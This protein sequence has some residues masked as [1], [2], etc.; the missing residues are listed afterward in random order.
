MKKYFTHKSALVETEKIGTKTRIWA[1]VHILPGATIGKNV[2]ICDNVFIENDVLIGN[3]VTIKNGAI[4]FDGVTLEDSV[5]IGPGVVFTNDRYPRSKRKDYKL[6][7]VII[8]KGATLGGGTSILA[9]ITVGEYSLVGAGSVVTQDIPAFSI[10]YGNPA[11][12]TGYICVCTKK[13]EFQN[14]KFNCDCGRKYKL[15][16]SKVK[17]C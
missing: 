16:N 2:N 11:K 15:V 12:F 17:L 14:D 10:A 1:F 4:L 13:M 7:K 3:N 8:K 6:E 5:F 9:G